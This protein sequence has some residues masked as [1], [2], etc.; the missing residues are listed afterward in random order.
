MSIGIEAPESER[1]P[2]ERGEG[3]ERGEFVASFA[4]GLSVIQ[5]F[6]PDSRRMTL[7]EVAE[8]TGLNRATARRFLLT[9]LELGLVAYDGKY[10]ELT[11]KILS[12]GY[13]YLSSLEFWDAANPYLAEITRVLQESCSAAVLDGP[14][15]VYVARSA[16]RHRLVSVGLHVGARLPAHA[17]SMGQVLLA[18]LDPAALA[19][20]FATARLQRFTDA[21]L[22]DRAA[23]E[24]R[25]DQVRAQ[26]Y[27]LVSE[28]LE[29]GLR[30]IA[31]P[32]RDRRGRSIASLNI[33]A[34][35]ARISSAEMV[36][37]FLPKLQEAAERIARMTG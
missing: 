36:E 20:Y 7:A 22:V 37:R 26:G 34:H 12:L 15:I 2:G 30:A 25:F 11:P 13:A 16:A 10:F 21:T 8:R 6:G 1:D 19:D 32:V 33:S 3:G 29:V 5:S 18:E 23:L 24:R 9:L 31:V 28:E 27:A 14:D 4:R 17:A 35:A